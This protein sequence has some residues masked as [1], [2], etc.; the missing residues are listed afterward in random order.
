ADDHEG[1]GG[2]GRRDR[3]RGRRLE[4]RDG[5]RAGGGGSGGVKPLSDV[6]E[7]AL[8]A[9]VDLARSD[10]EAGVERRWHHHPHITDRALDVYGV[11]E[12]TVGALSSRGWSRPTSRA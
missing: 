11:A 10:A 5:R 4:G 8:I 7:R 1:V 2:S 9:I 3:V 12:G 6:M